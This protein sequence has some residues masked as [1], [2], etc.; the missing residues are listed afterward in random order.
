MFKGVE[1]PGDD[2]GCVDSARRSG[3]LWGR[4]FARVWRGVALRTSGLLQ[5]ASE[6]LHGLLSLLVTSAVQ[7]EARPPKVARQQNEYGEPRTA[8]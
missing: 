6:L 8:S 4:S 2:L 1:Q 3:R 5:I 7:S